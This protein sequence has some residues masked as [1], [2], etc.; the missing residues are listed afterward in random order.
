MAYCIPQAAQASLP[1]NRSSNPHHDK[2]I[3]D[4]AEHHLRWNA[5]VT[6]AE[7]SSKRS[8]RGGVS[9]P[10]APAKRLR[11][12]VDDVHF[13]AA[14]VAIGHFCE[15]AIALHQ[16]SASLFRGLGHWVRSRLCMGG[17][18]DELEHSVLVLCAPHSALARHAECWFSLLEES[19][20]SHS[21]RDPRNSRF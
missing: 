8:L 6:T 12:K 10:N 3:A 21:L 15:V 4:L 14:V 18:I 20:D 7:D 16:K 17:A 11:I 5:S 2:F 13:L 9:V 1:E 19:R